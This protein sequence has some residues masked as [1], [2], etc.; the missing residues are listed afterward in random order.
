M[1][2]ERV[3]VNDDFLERLK[4]LDRA[5]T[6][7]DRLTAEVSNLDT[8]LDEDDLV[9]LLYGRRNG[10]NLSSIRDAFDALDSVESASSDELL[11]S[12]V[13]GFSG[14]GK[15]DAERFVRQVNGLRVRYGDAEAEDFDLLPEVG[16][17][18]DA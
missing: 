7:L 2:T 16:G 14:V 9:R 11:V 17:E 10:L 8:G 6:A 13:A 1:T 15:R 3:T 5:A 18:A 12:L 4:A